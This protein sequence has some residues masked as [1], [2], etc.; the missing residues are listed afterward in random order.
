M[1]EVTEASRSLGDFRRKVWSK[2]KRST[3]KNMIG[4]MLGAF[5]LSGSIGS[6]AYAHSN[7]QAG[8]MPQQTEMKTD[9]HPDVRMPSEDQAKY[10]S[11]VF[12]VS[13]ADVKQEI[14]KKTDLFDIGQAA[15]LAKLSGKPFPSVMQMKAKGMDWPEI[16]DALGITEK[17]LQA[18]LLD[19]AVLHISMRG[20]VD[21]NTAR[22]LL[23]KGYEPHDIEMAGVIAKAAHKDIRSVLDRKRDNN[24]WE[25][26]AD[27]FGVDKNLLKSDRPDFPPMRNM[28]AKN[29]S[30]N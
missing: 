30:A 20:D 13:E 4:M 5:I 16:V 15:M 9:H 19:M 7:E 24:S 29:K 6:L 28:P 14:T 27:E 21:E 1:Q 11:E 2:M 23:Q 18:G 10:V 3:K 25:N 26:V 17:N 12:G 22:D 8:H